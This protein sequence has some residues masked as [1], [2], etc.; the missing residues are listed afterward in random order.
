MAES[1]DE[2]TI[3]DEPE[4]IMEGESSSVN[5]NDETEEVSD[6]VVSL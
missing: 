3:Y 4:V 1:F 6:Q 2:E 5:D